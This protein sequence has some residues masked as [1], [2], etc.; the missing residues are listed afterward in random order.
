MLHD[1][2]Y[3]AI[4]FVCAFAVITIAIV[5]YTKKV[6]VRLQKAER[7]ADILE[8]IAKTRGWRNCGICGELYEPLNDEEYQP[9]LDICRGCLWKLHYDSTFDDS[10]DFNNP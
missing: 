10:R 3:V 9:E 2:L 8:D 4:G 7:K 6:L 1:I 5:V